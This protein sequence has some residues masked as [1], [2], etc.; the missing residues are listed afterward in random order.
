[1]WAIGGYGTIL[2]NNDLSAISG[3]GPIPE[4]LPR[5]SLITRISPNPFQDQTE[6]RL[7]I[8]QPGTVRIT[9]SDYTG[10]QMDSFTFDRPS[11]EFTWRYDGTRLPTGIYIVTATSGNRS[12]S[13]R[14]IK[15]SQQ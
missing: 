4:S 5:E 2:T 1:M 3:T 15:I 10:R 6:F 9:L 13:A 12:G 14:M 8:S 11:G 7:M